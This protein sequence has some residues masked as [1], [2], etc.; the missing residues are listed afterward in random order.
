M[1]KKHSTA[2]TAPV[3][4]ARGGAEWWTNRGRALLQLGR[5]EEA[6]AAYRQAVRLA[7]RSVDPQRSLAQLRFMLGREDH[8]AELYR[9]VQA[10]EPDDDALTLTLADVLANTG[11][12]EQAEGLL[13]AMLGESRGGGIA[14]LQLATLLQEAG[15]LQEAE[16]IALLGA[17]LRAHDPIVMD[18][19]VAVQMSLGLAKDALPVIE[20]MRRE[21]PTRPALAGAPGHC[22]ATAGRSAV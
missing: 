14:H 4:R 12:V 16:K 15:R 22:R 9:A 17:Q 8:A 20:H 2:W 18:R 3:A 13:Q 10:A 11:H 21:H 19:L 5:H 7:P 6:E 1:R